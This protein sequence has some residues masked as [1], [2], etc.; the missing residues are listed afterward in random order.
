MGAGD[1][2]KLINRDPPISENATLPV[3]EITRLYIA[4]RY[5]DDDA[6]AVRR[7]LQIPALPESWKA[8]FRE[9]L[10]A[11]KVVE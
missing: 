4:K 9:R 8:Y 2:L 10:Q 5:S 1:E 6:R 7:A 11:M 3:S